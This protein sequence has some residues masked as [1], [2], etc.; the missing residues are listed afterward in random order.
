VEGKEIVDLLR[1]DLATSPKILAMV[2]D[3]IAQDTPE[4]DGLCECDRRKQ[5]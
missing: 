2:K 1:N 5:Q 4:A 3:Q